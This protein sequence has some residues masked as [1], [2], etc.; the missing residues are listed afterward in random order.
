MKFYAMR[1]G[2]KTE[3]RLFVLA[4]VLILIIGNVLIQFIVANREQDKA[5][6][7]FLNPDSAQPTQ[8]NKR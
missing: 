1:L 3:S 5:Q 4:M 2:P 7:Q 6:E 8:E